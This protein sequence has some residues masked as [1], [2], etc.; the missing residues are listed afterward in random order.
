MFGSPETAADQERRNRNRKSILDF[1][2]SDAKRIEAK[3]GGADRRKLDEYLS[4]V[5][6]PKCEWLVLR[7]ARNS[8]TGVA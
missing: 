8:G 2:S 7:K 1:V 3:L 5:R 6:D 4:S